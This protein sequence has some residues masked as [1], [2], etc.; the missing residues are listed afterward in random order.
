MLNSIQ[1]NCYF[2]INK[3]LMMLIFF[4]NFDTIDTFGTVRNNDLSRNKNF[5]I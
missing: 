4:E 5:E 2:R 1:K 3:K